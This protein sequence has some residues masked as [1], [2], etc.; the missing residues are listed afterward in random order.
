[1]IIFQGLEDKVVPPNQAEKMVESRTAP[2]NCLS[3]TSLL[4]IE[5]AARLSQ[6]PRKYQ[7]RAGGGVIFL[8]ESLSGLRTCR[9]RGAGNCR[10][11]LE[12]RSV[13]V[14]RKNAVADFFREEKRDP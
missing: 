8:L 2:R 3:P 14:I 13:Q 4:K 6:S 12:R 5:R 9:T 10:K 1:M 11:S 7:T